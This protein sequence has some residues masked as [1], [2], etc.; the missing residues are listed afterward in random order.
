MGPYPLY[1]NLKY[2][3]LS[4]KESDVGSSL[5]C[6]W[7]VT[8]KL[9]NSVQYMIG[10][11]LSDPLD[12]DRGPK[13]QIDTRIQHSR[14]KAPEKRGFQKPWWRGSFCL[15]STIYCI[16]NTIYP[17]WILIVFMWS[18]GPNGALGLG[19]A[20]GVVILGLEARFGGPFWGILGPIRV[21]IA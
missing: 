13:D 18:S 3:P 14:S 21:M 10:G 6:G 19:C 17:S 5:D 15:L 20:F 1:G 12:M 4:H 11:G 8:V 9:R 7:L 2:A 16:L